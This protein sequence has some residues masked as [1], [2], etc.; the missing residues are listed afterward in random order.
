[1]LFRSGVLFDVFGS[2]IL[3][4]SIK[5]FSG[6]V[7]VV[8][9]SFSFDV[10]AQIY[11]FGFSWGSLGGADGEFDDAIGIA[12]DSLDNPFAAD[13]L[14]DRVQKF[15]PVAAAVPLTIVPLGFLL[16]ACIGLFVLRRHAA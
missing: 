2:S 11:T 12:V 5:P 13:T 4:K 1:M 6:L 16:L 9:I 10:I 7:F 15:N 3:P 8:G 14:N